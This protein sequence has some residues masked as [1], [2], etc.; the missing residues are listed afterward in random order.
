MDKSIKELRDYCAPLRIKR[1]DETTPDYLNYISDAI[2][3]AHRDILQFSP[4]SKILSI[5][6]NKKP[7]G[8]DDINTCLLYTSPSP[9]D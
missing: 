5:F 1:D 4:Y 2:D 8:L 3:Q 9:R 7:L 6:E